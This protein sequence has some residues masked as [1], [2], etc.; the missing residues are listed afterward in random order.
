M[1]LFAPDRMTRLTLRVAG[2]DAQGV[3]DNLRAR[4]DR[5]LGNSPLARTDST[6]FTEA[7]QRVTNGARAAWHASRAV[8][9]Q[10][11]HD[12]TIDV[13]VHRDRPYF[14]HPLHSF[15]TIVT[16]GLWSPIYYLRWLTS[17]RRRYQRARRAHLR[18][19]GIS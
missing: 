8:G 9:R 5:I 1:A 15:L 6:A 3:N 4:A 14:P 19:H 12:A 10:A 17:A 16:V 7:G 11:V 13:A 18:D 2:R